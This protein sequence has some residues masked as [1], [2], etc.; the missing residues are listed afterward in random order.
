MKVRASSIV[1]F[2]GAESSWAFN[3]DKEEEEE[4]N[5]RNNGGND[6]EIAPSRHAAHIK[7]TNLGNKDTEIKEKFKETAVSSSGFFG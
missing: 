4:L 1:L 6:P 7:A 5:D 2:V 3:G